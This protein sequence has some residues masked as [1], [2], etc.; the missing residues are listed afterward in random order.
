M[1]PRHNMFAGSLAYTAG[2]YLLIRAFWRMHL[3]NATPL[4]SAYAPPPPAHITLGCRLYT[5]L[6]R[7][8]CF[9]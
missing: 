9:F 8:F 7:Y 1:T 2:S 5:V 6:P 4:G 3:P